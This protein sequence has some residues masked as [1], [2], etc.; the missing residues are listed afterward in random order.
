M[1]EQN[2][3]P[4]LRDAINE[5][6]TKFLDDLTEDVGMFLCSE[7]L[8]DEKQSEDDIRTLVQCV[9]TA[10]SCEDDYHR[11]PIH[12]AIEN[13]GGVSLIPML[14]EEGRKHNVRGEGM[15]GG[16]LRKDPF[17]EEVCFRFS[18]AILL[19]IRI[20]MSSKGFGRWDSSRRRISRS[21]TWCGY[22]AT[23]PGDSTT[24]RTEILQH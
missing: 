2:L 21:I 17:S 20:S 13:S 6:A 9:P 11:L 14:I 22:L 4:D 8:D 15:R 1:I 10:L 19:V 16:L 3:S 23:S 12:N 5:K 24:S 7:D 18:R